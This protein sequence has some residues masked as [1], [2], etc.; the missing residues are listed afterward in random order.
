MLGSVGLLSPPT[1]AAQNAA[2]ENLPEHSTEWSGHS[3]RPQS[4]VYELAS[5][6]QENSGS[7]QLGGRLLQDVYGNRPLPQTKLPA[8][9]FTSTSGKEF[10]P[11]LVAKSKVAYAGVLFEGSIGTTPR[12]YIG[13]FSLLNAPEGD[14]ERAVQYT[15]NNINGCFNVA[16]NY[17]V[18]NV[19]GNQQ[20]TSIWGVY[21]YMYNAN[22]WM[23]WGSVSPGA[24]NA[25]IMYDTAFDPTTTDVV[26]G[27]MGKLPGN[28]ETIGWYK[29]DMN[30]PSFTLI[31]QPQIEVRGVAASTTGQYYAIASDGKVYTVDKTT[32][33]FT[34]LGNSGAVSTYRTTAA[35]DQLS[36]MIYYVTVNDEG[37]S[38][39]C[40]DPKTGA[41]KKVYDFP[42]LLQLTNLY[43]GPREAPDGAPAVPENVTVNFKPD[44]L[45]GAIEFDVPE[46]TYDDEQGDGRVKY[47]VRLQWTVDEYTG[48]T[49]YED[50]TG[51]T[52]YGS[53]VAEYITLP[54]AK[55]YTITVRCSNEVGDGPWT[56]SV[57]K[58][59]GPDQPNTPYSFK[60]VYEDG[61]WKLSWDA[62]SATGVYGGDIDP[63]AV[64]YVL[65]FM[66]EGRQVITEGG[67]TSY[68]ED[69]P[70]PDEYS[71]YYWTCQAK[72]DYAVASNIRST[73]KVG[74]GKIY[75]YWAEDF[76]S[77]TSSTKADALAGYTVVD[78]AEKQSDWSWVSPN[79]INHAYYR[80]YDADSYF[81]LPKIYLYGGRYYT[82]NFNVGKYGTAYGNPQFRVVMGSDLTKEGLNETVLLDKTTATTV[83][84]YENRGETGDKYSVTFMP[85]KDGVYY[86]AFH[87][88]NEY[89]NVS[90]N[91]G[92]YN[93]RVSNL[94]ITSPI[95]PNA[96]EQVKNLVAEA[97]VDGGQKVTVS[98]T[99]PRANMS[100]TA[101]IG[102]TRAEIKRGDIMIADVP[103]TGSTFK[104]ID[105]DPAM[106]TNTY[107]V[108]PYNNDGAG[109]PLTTSCFVGMAAPGD[110]AELVA[111]E[112]EKKGTVE[113]TW[114]PVTK[115]INGKN[116][117]DVRYAIVRNLGGNNEIITQDLTTCEYTDRVTKGEQIQ[118]VYGVKAI[119]PE[120]ISE[121]WAASKTLLLGNA[122]ETPYIES[123]DGGELSTL[124]IAETSNTYGRWE[125]FYDTDFSDLKSVDH[126]NGFLG[127]Y[128]QVSGSQGA[129]TTGRIKIPKELDNPVFSFYFFLMPNGTNNIQV[130]IRTDDNPTYEY[131]ASFTAGDTRK[132]WQVAAVDMTPYLGRT[133]QLT[134]VAT[135]VS[136][137]YTLFDRLEVH[138]MPDT[139]INNVTISSVAKAELNSEVEVKVGYMNASLK[140]AEDYKVLILRDGEQIAEIPGESV[141]I[142]ERALVSYTDVIP[143]TAGD[144][145]KYEAIVEIDGDANE[146]DNKT[147]EAAIVTVIKPELPTASELVGMRNSESEIELSWEEPDMNKRP[148]E[149]VTEGFEGLKT[150]D[151]EVDGWLNL[152]RDGRSVGFG[153]SSNIEFPE[154][155]NRVSAAPWLAVNTTENNCDAAHNGDVFMGACY[156]VDKS[157]N[158]DWLISPELSGA[159]QTISVW[160]RS[161]T[162]FYGGDRIEILYSTTGRE[163][164]N[165]VSAF[166]YPYVP[167]SWTECKVELPEGAKYFAIR[168]TSIY[169]I[170]LCV[171]DVTYSPAGAT[172]QDMTLKGYNLWRNGVK[173]NDTLITDTHYKDTVPTNDAYNY[174]VT[175]VYDKGESAASNKETVNS[176]NVS[177]NSVSQDNAIVNVVDR[178]IRVSNATG[179]SVDIFSADGKNIH[180]GTG[181]ASVSVSPGVY[182][183]TIGSKVV[184]VIVG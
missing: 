116:L 155:E 106:G 20:F 72:T 42:Q 90:G 101:L 86:I 107:T 157:T 183:V 83:A 96:P 175:A 131:L 173:L 145:V 44:A 31:S 34:E 70:E 7:L 162:N 154:L 115:D 129:L 46:L 87:H 120:G 47:T 102:M 6:S 97:D 152:D 57:I 36:D 84:G 170:M 141:G 122:Y 79:W 146:S 100:G 39:Y 78:F 136:H 27:W 142:C 134:L 153:G 53:H 164:T 117:K 126:D 93:M 127:F 56:Q 60:G 81:V 41:G 16:N 128:S 158:D 13:K 156:L 121:N 125:L 66:P 14:L 10:G 167:T 92:L 119:T 140:P 114:T 150:G 12:M 61:K 73:S 172:Y 181:D 26:Y 138:S 45:S 118:A 2:V 103:L 130:L 80:G 169:Q 137:T 149:T 54:E 179:L 30:T 35:Y 163:V 63:D 38:L 59:I 77:Y 75:P 105:T 178:T 64:K 82:F 184:K 113:L 124:L 91:A 55:K 180:S 22:T 32:G 143:Q 123:L 71:Q 18:N 159:A 109:N 50:Y 174:H 177:V 160:A 67:A 112:T 144:T 1:L 135:T 49:T 4:N 74:L 9:N 161:Y 148:L 147:N 58:Y 48:E 151:T 5:P 17:I 98:F 15:S 19:S 165:F 40:I 95:I 33:V 108:T 62:H 88:C 182:V 133:V 166:E 89:L 28:N 52:T 76:S 110:V 132:G 168:C 21:W 25:Y 68:E 8:G 99:C 23:S 51:S 69:M 43:F 85:E 11:A 139:D 176:Y 111:V 65:T 37:S 3:S 94:E 171:D 29:L 104:W 24:S